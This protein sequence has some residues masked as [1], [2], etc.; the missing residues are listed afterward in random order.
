MTRMGCPFAIAITFLLASQPAHGRSE[1]RLGGKDGN[2]WQDVLSGGG[3][4]LKLDSQSVARRVQVGVPLRGG[5]PYGD[6][7]VKLADFS[8]T[9]IRPLHIAPEDNLVLADVQKGPRLIPLPLTGGWINN[10]S[11][12]DRMIGEQPLIASMFDG[13][14]TTASFFQEGRYAPVPTIDFGGAVPVNRFRFYPRLGRQEDLDV[15]RSL[16]EPA[17]PETAF[18]V[19]SFSTNVLS[20]YDIRVG[21]DGLPFVPNSCHELL[22]GMR[23]LKRN[24]PDMEVVVDTEENLD[25]VVDLTFPTRYVRWMTFEPQPKD[26][27]EV[28]EFEVFGEG[29]VQEMV[30]RTPVLDF[31]RR[32]NWSKIR[33]S[34]DF[35]FGTQTE[36][37]TR[38]GNTPDPNRYFDMDVNGN[39]VPISREEYESINALVRQPLQIDLDN[40]SSWTSPYEIE[41]GRRDSSLA[42]EAW[43]DAT[44][45][46]SF[47]SSRYL[48]LEVKFISRFEAGPRLDQIAI[49]FS[50]HPAAQEVV[51]EI[52]P[53]EVTSF[54]ATT[55]TYVISPTFE[56]EDTGFDRLEIL[57][58][59]RADAVR[60]V[61]V[62]DRDIDLIQFPPRIEHDRILVALPFREAHPDSSLKRI[63]V[64]FDVEV[65]RFG[66]QFTGWIYDSSDADPVKQRIRPGNATYR[67]SSD[68]LSVIAPVGGD[69]LAD[70]TV[71]PNP[72]T[73]NGDGVNDSTA[74]SYK[75]REV[76]A[77]REVSLEIYDLAGRLVYRRIAEP[78]THGGNKELTWDGR[79]EA[80]DLVAPGTYLYRL[81]LDVKDPEEHLGVVAVVY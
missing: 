79:T 19:D 68:D 81:R 54:D 9:S 39:P 65:L 27:W 12:C 58:H 74:V 43:E 46:I 73:P 6:P 26:Q 66:T 60:S 18:P 28:A 20:G 72:F 38:T 42:P 45:M 40:W 67:F 80:G 1:Y 35:P 37:R 30:Y 61:K 63:E 64:I 33:W 16:A 10:E 5:I 44:R 77:A 57:T 52:W 49:R 11:K 51:G 78:S 21:G 34:G 8:G 31:G 17:H 48:Q 56:A 41:R 62:D 59:T 14:P 55:F 47:G 15:I 22:P 50:E 2:P 36:I 69:L 23:V 7:Q 32:V 75:L 4:Y 70:L 13:D 29:F 24:D 3:E 71:A 76:T 25:L 53:S